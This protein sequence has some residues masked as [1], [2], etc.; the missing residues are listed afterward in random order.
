MLKSHM[1]SSS[2]DQRPLTVDGADSRLNCIYCWMYVSEALIA[3]LETITRDDFCVSEMQVDWSLHALLWKAKRET[4]CGVY[5]YA[6]IW[7]EKSNVPTRAVI[8]Y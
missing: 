7:L 3:P 1:Y 8:P 5:Y 4:E 2:Y 6:D